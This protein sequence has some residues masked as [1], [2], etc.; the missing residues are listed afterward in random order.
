MNSM[1]P[2]QTGSKGGA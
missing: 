1:G 2:F